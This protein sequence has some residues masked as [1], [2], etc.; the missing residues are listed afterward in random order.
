MKLNIGA[1]KHSEAFG[2][3]LFTLGL[4]LLIQTVPQKYG[5]HLA[6]IV[7][8]STNAGCVKKGAVVQKTVGIAN[9]SVSALDVA[10]RS[11]CGCNLA[12]APTQSIP[13]FGF[14]SFKETID[15]SKATTG[16]HMR[17]LTYRLSTDRSSWQ[18]S[19]TVHYT[20]L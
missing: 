5:W 6:F 10:V 7:G 14:A 12:S 11:S 9:L 19:T 1:W 20:I 13:P 15:T 2:R 3:M 18:E 8:R 17:T 16:Q 4:L